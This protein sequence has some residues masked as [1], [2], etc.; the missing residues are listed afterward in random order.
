MATA[1]V[2][3]CTVVLL[4]NPNTGKSTLFQALTGVRQ[5]VGN[6]PG[7]TVEKREGTLEFSGQE[8]TIV[9]LP[10]TYSLA[11]RSPDEMVAVDIVL[12][13][14]ADTERPDVILCLADATNLARNLFLASQ[15]LDVGTPLVLALN[16][17]DLARDRGIEIDV[18]GLS[19]RLGV[20]VV[21]LEAHRK[22]GLESLKRALQS[23][24]GQP[25]HAPLRPMPA[26]FQ[27]EV[28][29]MSRLLRDAG[30]DWDEFL[31]ERLLLDTSGP[32]EHAADLRGVVHLSQ[33][34]REARA[35]L[36]E[37]GLPVPAVEAISR[38]AWI[39]DV[40]SEVQTVRPRAQRRWSDRIDGVLT[41]RWW[42]SLIFLAVM[43]LVFQS[44]FT[45][46]EPAMRGL[47]QAMDWLARGAARGLGEGPLSSLVVDGAL[48]G[49]GSVIVFLP[50]IVILFF[51]LALLEDCGYLAR[52]AYLMDRPMSRVGL[53][54]KSFIPLLSSFA[55]AIPGILATRVIENRRDRLVTILVAPLMSCS[56]RLPVYT[57][58]I[59]TFIPSRR[60]LG[61]WIDLQ[62]G[63]MFLMYS[64]GIVVAIG[65]SWLMTGTIF[66]GELSLF[67]ME[68]PSYKWP[69][70]RVVLGRVIDRGWAF[71]HRAGTLIVAVSIV[72]WALA[73]FPRTAPTATDRNG[74]TVESIDRQAGDS[75]R[76]SYLGRAGHYLEPLVRPLGW[77]WRIGSAVIASFPAREV[78]VG[79]M[80]VLYN[81]GSEQDESS[82]ALR[83]AMRQVTWEGTDRKV[84]TIPVALSL[85]VFFALC[86]QC[87]A[88]LV[89]IRRE[90]QSW[91]WPLFAF[92][93]MT[94]LAYVGALIAYRVGSWWLA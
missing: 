45:W 46:S 78:V 16:M 74:Q 58:L 91:K 25:P 51:L 36:T 17:M 30:V 35:R 28:A 87:A 15:L 7:V 75:L 82:I 65:V 42:G 41:H 44:I 69:S 63:T 40:V 56:A 4:G 54:G 68:L 2:S 71:V 81:L 73:Y 14:R 21:P 52:A 5:R 90:T 79:V 9:D 22:V 37:Q 43:L 48:A 66:R 32:L 88:T 93:Y 89:V 86:A 6:Y 59:E 1:A 34:L 83:Q 39:G 62:G 12:G 3:R 29:G 38:Y 8:F 92:V 53:S 50:Q 67:V 26:G 31:V 77:D 72:M 11:P 47:E 10:G 27:R 55:C 61:G 94:T 84:F 80:G 57:L 19:R 23:A 76:H 20:P 24:A 60:I 49:F 64:L 85:L 18:A 70:P 13:R 33:K